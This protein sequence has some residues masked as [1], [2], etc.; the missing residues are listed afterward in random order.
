MH[1]P[2]PGERGFRFVSAQVTGDFVQ[3][4]GG[5]VHVG[6]PPVSGDPLVELGSDGPGYVRV[7]FPERADD[8]GNPAS[9]NAE[10]RWMDSSASSVTSLRAVLHADR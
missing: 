9:W 6:K 5:A 4:G 1:V 10:A 3:H 2:G 8:V 7:Y